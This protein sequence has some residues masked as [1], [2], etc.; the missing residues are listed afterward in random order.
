MSSKKKPKITKEQKAELKETARVS[1][2]R[3]NRITKTRKHRLRTSARV[4]K[5]GTKS[6]VRNAWLS[7]AAIAIMA[8][9]LIVL[10]ATIIATSAMSSAI[11]AVESQVDMSV[12]IKQTASAEQVRKITE[13]MQNLDSVV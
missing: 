9:T 13:A 11:K 6:F 7:M 10:S 12:Y 1:K 8:V 5:Y 4:M 3:L 2:E